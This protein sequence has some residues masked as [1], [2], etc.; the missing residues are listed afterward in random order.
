MFKM[1]LRLL[2]VLALLL[3]Q[4]VPSHAQT[5][6]APATTNS[7]STNA[8]AATAPNT[9]AVGDVITQAPKCDDEIAAVADQPRS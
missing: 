6:P 2:C 1:T 3:T 4:A 5:A 8:P 9:Y 7:P